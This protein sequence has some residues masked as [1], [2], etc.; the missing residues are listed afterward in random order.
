MRTNQ[1]Q[2]TTSKTF[3]DAG[4]RLW[5]VL[6]IA[7]SL[8]P[9]ATV[10]TRAADALFVYAGA[11]MNASDLAIS[12]RLATLGFNVTA[13]LATAS[14][15]AQGTNKALIVV[16]STIN[17]GDAAAKFLNVTA[18]V[19]AWENAIFDDMLWTL[20][21]GSDHGT[22]GGQQTLTI[23]NPDHPLAAGLKGTV[24]VTR[25]PRTFAFGLPSTNAVVIA[26]STDGNNRN[27]LF[28]Y[29]T[30][31]TLIDGKS[32][33]LGR[34]V[35]IF[36]DNNTPEALTDDGWTL[37]DTAVSWG[38]AD[39][40]AVAIKQQPASVSAL[41]AA[42]STATFSV[43]V[44]GGLPYSFQWKKNGF[45]IAGA[46]GRSYTT[47]ALALTDNGAKFSVT[48]KNAA[49][50]VTSSD[51]AVSISP[52]TT[53]PSIVS[54]SGSP[55]FGEA[56]V[57]YSEPVLAATATNL[58]NYSFDPPVLAV[59]G[60]RI[61][62]DGRTVVLKTTPQA[63]GGTYTLKVLGVRD[64]SA[65]LNPIAPGTE[66]SFSG[67]VLSRAALL[68]EAFNG[69]NGT[70]ITDLTSSAK[71]TNNTPDF[72]GVMNS[73]NTRS[74]Y[75]DDSHENYGARISGYFTPPSNG[76]YRLFIKSDDAS[77][78]FMNT[79]SVNSTDPSAKK[80]IAREDACCKLYGDTSAGGPRVSPDIALVGGQKYYIEGLLKEGGGG[81]YLQATF[82]EKAVSGNPGDKAANDSNS[83]SISGLYL[84]T[85]VNPDGA[86]ITVT[87]QPQSVT[88]GEGAGTT[89]TFSVTATAITQASKNQAIIY[90]WQKDGIDIPGA[91][92]SSYKATALAS[93]SGSKFRAT[94]IIPGK[95]VTTSEAT[96]TVTRDSTPP[97][98]V[99]ANTYSRPDKLTVTFSEPVSDSSAAKTSNYSLNNGVTVTG[100]TKTSPNTV[101][102]SITT[103]T[104]P[105]PPPVIAP[106][107]ISAPFLTE[108]DFNEGA[109]QTVK[110]K[111]GK[112]TGAFVGTPTFSSDTPSGAKGDFSL[113]IAAGQRIDVPDPSKVIALD[114][115]I[116][117]FTVQAWLKFSTPAAR[118]VFFYNNGPGG[119]VSASV[120]TNRTAFVT[121]LGI[122][123]QGS[124]AAIPNDGGW[125]HMAVVHDA[126]AKEI[127]FYVD[128]VLGDTAT[129]YTKG[130]IFTRTNQFFSLGSEFNNG[131]PGLQ[132]VGLL[133]RF[134]YSKGALK[135]AELDSNPDPNAP[136]KYRIGVNFG[137]NEANG[138]SSGTLSP[139]AV[140]GVV[141]QSNWNNI[142]G[143]NGSGAAVAADINGTSQPTTMRVNWTSNGTWAS[144]GRSEENNKFPTN[145]ADRVLMIGYLDTGA[146]TTSSITI[147]GIPAELAA[148][149]YD[150][151]IYAMGGVGGR[152]GGYR[153][154]DLTS[155]QVLRDY[156]RV[157]SPTNSTGFIQAPVS[158]GST[159]YAV[160]NYFVMGGLNSSSITIEA[161]TASGYGFGGTPRAPINAI[162]LVQSVPL[163][164]GLSFGAN[165][166]NGNLTNSTAVVGV[167]GVA[168]ANWNNLTGAN[169]TNTTVV[170]DSGGSSQSTG[171]RVQWASNGT[172]AIAS[173]GEPN[174]TNFAVGTPNHTLMEGYLD[175]G[176]TTTTSVSISGVPSQ[177][178]GKGYDVYVYALGG[179]AGRGGAYRILDTASGQVLKDYVLAQ[180][181][182]RPD[183]FIQVPTNLAPLQ[184][185]AGNYIVFSGLTSSAIT[186]EA[187]TAVPFGFSGTPRAPVNAVQLVP[188]SALP[189]G[190]PLP[191][192][193]LTVTVNG[194]QDLA[195]KP[196]I[197]GANTKLAIDSSIAT[198]AD[199]SQFVNGYQTDFS[200]GTLPPNWV[201]RGATN[202][203]S[204]SNGYLHVT[205]ANG[206][207]NHL[208]FEAPGYNQTNQ[209]VLVRMRIIAFGPNG[210][211]PRGGIGVGVGTNS[212]GINLHFRDSNQTDG[213]T[214]INGRQLRLLDDLRAW[215]PGYDFRPVGANRWR[216][217]EWYWVRLKQ[218]VDLA[219]GGADV[220]AKAWLADGTTPEPANWQ[221]TWDRYPAAT[222]RAGFAGITA[223]SANGVS[224]FDVDYFLL[225]ADGL[226]TI[227]PGGSDV[228]P[229]SALFV[230]G[231]T[232]SASDL[233]VS[234]RIATLGYAVTWKTA[235]S[236]VTSDGVGRDIIVIS[237]T[238]NSGDMLVN[239]VHK[240]RDLAVPIMNWESASYDDLAI[241]GTAS[242]EFGT[243]NNMTAVNVVKPGHPLAGGLPAGT[244]T[245]FTSPQTM[246]WG[247]P[248]ANSIVIA[249]Q[250]DD[251]THAVIF[252][253]EQGDDL[254]GGIKAAERRLGFFLQDNGGT[255][256]APA[257]VALFD[258]AI[259]WLNPSIPG[260]VIASDPADT[261]AQ[262]NGTA[263][264]T[265]DAN[266]ARPF[267][268]QWFKNNV[269]IA[270]AT[271]RILTTPVT[272]ADNG[273]SFTVKVTN[274]G[275]SA[276]SKGAKLTVTPDKT[277]PTL[278]SAGTRGNPSAITVT[279]SKPV[280][281]T[282]GLNADN[283]SING[284][285][286]VLGA[287]FGADSS[288]VIL[289]ITGI[290]DSGAYTLTVKNVTDR[291]G[292]PNKITPNPSTA[293]IST[294]QGVILQRYYQFDVA[295]DQLKSWTNNAR[296]PNDPTFVTFENNLEYPPNGAGE[297][298]S[299][300]GNQLIGY[301]HPPVTGD[302]VF[303]V[304]SDDQSN[305]YLST[306]DNPANKRFIAGEPQWNNARQWLVPD[307]RTAKNPE[308]RS[309]P[310]KLEAGKKYF[311]EVIHGEGGGGDNVGVAWQMPGDKNPPANGSAPISGQYLSTILPSGPVGI[312][313]QPVSVTARE[314]QSATLS[315]SADGTPPFGYQ[316]Y[317]NGVAIKGATGA[318]YTIPNVSLADAGAAFSV[319]VN[320]GF[321]VVA[322]GDA[323]LKVTPDPV[324]PVLLSAI[325]GP[326]L[327]EV[328]LKFT[329]P[330]S[331]ASATSV[332]NYAI[333]GGV[334]V[335]IPVLSADAK[336]VT[337]VT[338][339]QQPSTEYTVTVNGVRDTASGGNA[340]PANSTATFTSWVPLS[341][342]LLREVYSNI[343]GGAVSDL[344]GNAKFP[345]NP[346]VVEFRSSFEAQ[347]SFADNYGQKMSG[348]VTAPESGNYVFYL[349]SD[350]N[351]ALFLS[352]DEN[353]V[354]KRLIA[355]ESVW[356][357]SR[358]WVSSGGSSTLA[359]K[360]S[361]Q[362]AGTQWP[363]GNTITLTAGKRYYIEALQKEGGGGDNLG[364]TWKIP[365]QSAAVTN[366]VPPIAGTYLS[367][368]ANSAGASVVFSMQPQSVTV[369]DGSATTLTAAAHGVT[370]TS[371]NLPVVYQWQRNG[372]NINGATGSTYTTP[373]LRIGD[374]G[375]AYRVFVAV[376]GFVAF[377]DAAVVTVVGDTVPPT[378]VSA[379]TYSRTNKVSVIF[380]E[381]VSDAS[382]IKAASYTI[383]NGVTVQSAVKTAPNTVELTTTAISSAQ[384]NVLTVSGVQDVAGNSIRAKSRVLI[385]TN[386]AVP[387]EF[388]FAV[389]GYQDD[390][391][392]ATLNAG[393]KARGP[394]TNVY[395]VANG[396][397]S[398]TNA[399]GDPNHLLYEVA[400]YNAS[401]QEVLVRMRLAQFGTDDA[402]RAGIGVGVGTNSQGM[403]LHFRDRSP[404]TDAGVTINGRQMRLLDDN[405]AWGPGF[406]FR[407]SGTNRWVTNA[408][409]WLR[410]KQQVNTVAGQ[411]DVFAKAW[412]ADGTVPEPADWQVTWDRYP[413]ATVRSGFA[414]ITAGSNAD[415]TPA[416][417][418]AFD[419][420]YILIKA[421]GLPAINVEASAFTLLGRGNANGNLQL[422]GSIRNAGDQNTVIVTDDLGR[423]GVLSINRLDGDIVI[424]FDASPGQTFMIQASDDMK[425]WTEIG[426]VTGSSQGR[427]TF[428]DQDSGNN[429]KRF[430]RT[431]SP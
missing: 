9:F 125:H 327:T 196:N 163:R 12:N 118:A 121:T 374:S 65:A 299:N 37:F 131:T 320:N 159:N 402:S 41:D 21:S 250:V 160:G 193:G 144:T 195:E 87:Q 246:T 360:R 280:S 399:A 415:G 309:A 183:T 73:F 48:V 281:D 63:A 409:Y 330:L 123:D 185:G 400:G 11:P 265:A 349:S 77:Q 36:L 366:T 336:T 236:V 208:L 371:S 113:Q 67:W 310:I 292:T 219:S 287:F 251:P 29:D 244:N 119:A 365:S 322:S 13:V 205:T 278:V 59:T 408:W 189:P 234:N 158:P 89:A 227:K 308:N 406:D 57:T 295:S 264:F 376:P 141:A 307:R 129:G 192:S 385:D 230:T 177:L 397:L 110:S 5:S 84:S 351:S 26:K 52:D 114:A 204:V 69:I 422:Q 201:A 414:G 340:I 339:P 206:D 31:A 176:N 184:Y 237:S 268:Y 146:P 273:A 143:Q 55:S 54:V 245:V 386:P 429:E 263:T 126:T 180:S 76:L 430:Y 104:V 70:A 23:V 316:W 153:V 51:A 147:T 373:V 96:L 218:Q 383:N 224:V 150:L 40:S 395:S 359:S 102:L 303:F 381:A 58:L 136:P 318:R 116:P 342:Y 375:T 424:D 282:D 221:I 255:A 405:R 187:T 269:A 262:E 15:T 24:T 49:G 213:G 362:Y 98:V 324:P 421:S 393:W 396:I 81:D 117:S 198:P 97:S 61:S 243:V 384:F 294:A 427:A 202:V 391:S 45:D 151:Y 207:P 253:N 152:G 166:V 353:P 338:T 4:S 370:K 312:T 326:S 306:D 401:N 100:A 162:Q 168:Q 10:A 411:V 175:T 173:R 101:D 43:I 235:P 321:S 258:A 203:Y 200:S 107:P 46:T 304:C 419:V 226:S 283:Y 302:Y 382:A 239:G 354:N 231:A 355:V 47:P 285:V 148:T 271:S 238:I 71:Y 389:N 16:S 297:A 301:L 387:A 410:L 420:D 229:V 32:K 94:L 257:A 333:S 223:G 156:V 50:S 92:Q 214:T 19:I 314:N 210:D 404:Q 242:S 254:F 343:G 233:V 194:V 241:T 369:T 425:S 174:G 157:Q 418:A 392:A 305:L 169:G 190:P 225:K 319:V 279:F 347:T 260:A 124:K 413:A 416:K 167:P 3:S 6:A 379:G 135:A 91:N 2:L 106:P 72:V 228:R 149:G 27:V 60:A 352:T 390:F 407:P 85:F 403:N 140:A 44:S 220:F 14:T 267:T 341:G 164:I 75:P 120:F 39:T 248:L 35:G 1:T 367:T 363:F 216:T 345:N 99:A 179:V 88:V 80:L 423:R 154:L 270:D 256:P 139:T 252:G 181:P 53:P 315:V 311:I 112:L 332:G 368:G 247:K 398:V 105:P 209:E 68:F 259:A 38:I 20:N 93:I 128:G 95:E 356:S 62:A 211:Q 8:L 290:P 165:E 197:I 388:G 191:T 348:F 261:S 217:N 172:W 240:F 78:L 394:S 137:A 145:S 134:K 323:T 18:P 377:T 335:I 361:D 138:T 331:S 212:Q 357:N 288:T 56:T 428:L 417:A 344:T 286:G 298:G 133:D 170:A 272:M 188:T 90:Q 378:L 33:A 28:A 372:V 346:D 199:F 289:A 293:L 34:R 17:S 109:G 412:L 249:R 380:S 358:E 86:S 22:I 186:L 82:R 182:F 171:V 364:V 64:T 30:G 313:A 127:R 266:G 300:Y 7:L 155:K 431:I 66:A 325:G 317:R 284:G 215:G 74:I 42:G 350:D 111:D 132:Y 222:V 334:K 291:S 122:V 296:F 426:K 142:S 130:T 337:I 276:T 232:P 277:G 115:K 328:T 178:S 161:T 274:A 83:E 25:D 103:A 329:K 275:G 108:F 79:N